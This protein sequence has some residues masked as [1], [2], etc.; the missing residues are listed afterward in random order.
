MSERELWRLMDFADFQASRIFKA[1]HRVHQMW[2]MVSADGEANIATQPPVEDK[3]YAERIVR[4]LFETLE[5][6]RYVFIGEAW[7]AEIMPEDEAKVLAHLQR[8]GDLE[9]YP[10][11]SEVLQLQGEDCEWGH[12]MWSRKIIRPKTGA[13]CIGPLEKHDISEFVSS[14]RLVG[15]LPKRKATLH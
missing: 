4:K 13:P 2:H 11:R 6:V 15:L 7:T 8:E 14:G 1:T 9:N 5:V 10:G 3:D 12:M